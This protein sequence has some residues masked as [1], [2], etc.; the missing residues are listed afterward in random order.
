MIIRLEAETIRKSSHSFLL[1]WRK[2]NSR[3]RVILEQFVLKSIDGVYVIHQRY[4]VLI[5]ARVSIV[6]MAVLLPAEG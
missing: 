5:Y 6:P 2:Y 3:H 4:W 1:P